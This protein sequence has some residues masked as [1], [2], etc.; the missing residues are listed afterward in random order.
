MLHPVGESD[1]GSAGEHP[2]SDSRPRRRMTV[3]RWTST[4]GERPWQV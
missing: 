2:A 3:S 4:K 1:A